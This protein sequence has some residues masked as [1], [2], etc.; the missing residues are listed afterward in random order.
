MFVFNSFFCIRG[1][2]V[3]GTVVELGIF[4]VFSLIMVKIRESW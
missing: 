4:S 1:A 3:V 2:V